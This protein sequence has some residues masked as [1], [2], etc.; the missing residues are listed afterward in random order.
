MGIPSVGI[1]SVDILGHEGSTGIPSMGIPAVG[2]CS[3]DILG[4]EGPRGSHPSAS[5]IPW[6]QRGD[7]GT[8]QGDT[9][10]PEGNRDPGWGQGTCELMGG[11][12]HYPRGLEGTLAGGDVRGQGGHEGTRS[13]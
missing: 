12:T 8:S 11:D 2:I 13:T 9:G 7:W 10:A 3:I 5:L 4:H 1:R 6:G